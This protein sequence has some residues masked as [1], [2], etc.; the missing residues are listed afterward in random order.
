LEAPW[1]RLVRQGA[2]ALVEGRLRACERLA[3]DAARLEPAEAAPRLLAAIAR[4]EQGRPSEAEVLVRALLA[5]HPD[6]DEGH[7]LL[8]SVLADLGR[9]GEARRQLDL[10]QARDAWRNAPSVAA[11]A[12]ETVAD[13][14][15]TEYAETIE[16]SLTGAS[17]AGWHGCPALHLGLLCHT[18]GRWDEAE[19]WFVFAIEANRAIGAPVLLAHTRRHFSALLRAR[20]GDGDW[21]R[22]IELLDEAATVYRRLDIGRL[23]DEAEAVLRRSQ[24]PAPAGTDD[25][26]GVFRSTP[27]GWELAFAGEEAVVAGGAGMAHVA[28]LLAAEGRPVH[29]LDLIAGEGEPDVAAEYRA[30]LARLAGSDLDGSDLD[31]S[32]LDGSDLDGSDPD[33]IGAA[34]DRAEADLLQAELAAFAPTLHTGGAP[35]EADPVDRARRLVALRIRTGLDQIEPALPALAG[36]LRRSI[37]TGTLCLYEPEGPA[38]WKIVR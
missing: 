12:A 25:G 8:G 17:V 28:A 7:A 22:A 26:P 6:V 20:G 23:A 16:A 10:L 37:R 27:D 38:R 29:A 24:D 34:L 30:R 32:D 2:E 31:G 4:R 3:G 19:T 11:L 21:E 5:E 36:H 14:D 15:A 33:P 35:A 9:D 18:L 13:L 1:S